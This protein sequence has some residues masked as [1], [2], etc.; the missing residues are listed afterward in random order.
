MLFNGLILTTTQAPKDDTQHNCNGRG[1]VHKPW[2]QSTERE[3]MLNK[4]E[5][6]C[7]QRLDS[8]YMFGPMFL[9]FFWYSLSSHYLSLSISQEKNERFWDAQAGSFGLAMADLSDEL[10]PVE[11]QPGQDCSDGE[12][13]KSTLKKNIFLWIQDDPSPFLGSIWRYLKYDFEAIA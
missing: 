5:C 7:D 4:E 1:S 9:H 2:M 8:Q 3:E 13:G 10:I 11:E 12:C 6:W